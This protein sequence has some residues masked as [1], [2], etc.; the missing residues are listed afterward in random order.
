MYGG[1][2]GGKLPVLTTLNNPERIGNERHSHYQNDRPIGQ[3][4]A[5]TKSSSGT[6]GL[7]LVHHPGIASFVVGRGSLGTL[8]ARRY[9]GARRLAAFLTLAAGLLLILAMTTCGGGGGRHVRPGDAGRDLHRYSHG[10]CEF[11]LSPPEP[12]RAPY[13]ESQLGESLVRMRRACCSK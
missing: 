13:S 12:W 6:T 2:L 4:A 7:T 11:G 10:K 1:T 3:C 8:P 9:R 5:L